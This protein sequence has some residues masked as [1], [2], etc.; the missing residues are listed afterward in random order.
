MWDWEGK[1]VDEAVVDKLFHSYHDYFKKNQLGKDKFLTFRIPNIWH[2]K[3]YGLA[4]ALMGI[5]TAESFAADLGLHTP[6]LF[7]V[8][9]PMTTSA[10]QLL[11]I[12]HKFHQASKYEAKIFGDKSFEQDTLEMIPLIEGSASL[13]DSRPILHAYVAGYEKR[14]KRRPAYLRPFIARSDPALDAG[15]VAATLSAR[16]AISEYYRFEEETDIRVYPIL[17]AGSLPFRGGLSPDTL[18]R[19]F[20]LY[21]GVRTV[22]IQSAFRY[23]FPEER[24]MSAI[25]QIKR[26]LPRLPA[27]RFSEDDLQQMAA[28]ARRFASAYR[29]VVAALAPMINDFARYVPSHRERIPHTGHFGYSRRMGKS[30]VA[31]PRA[32]TFTAV[33]ASLGVPPTL[34]GTG[35]ALKELIKK[36]EEKALRR[37]FPDFEVDLLASGYYLNREN[38]DIL[39]TEHDAWRAIRDDVLAIE[40]FLGCRL[41]PQTHDH[42]IHRNFSS[43]CY[44]LWRAGRSVEIQDAVVAAAVTRRSLG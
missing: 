8:I 10:H 3:G 44:H 38:L 31:L 18:D 30:T 26:T 11:E 19:F 24:V 20:A 15:F 35:R 1:Y 32:I 17:G 29:P 13:F 37:F 7:E 41:G 34:I 42:F 40:D 27:V 22:T 36:G 16:G 6:P 25:A 21:G 9:L 2:E 39:I 43:N 14:Y 5:L 23:D 33:F 28:M 4:R 12:L